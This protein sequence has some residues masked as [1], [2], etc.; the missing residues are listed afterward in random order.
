MV[1][2]GIRT[3]YRLLIC[4]AILAIIVILSITPGNGRPDDSVFSWLVINTATP[5]QKFMHITSYAVASALLVWSMKP[6][7][8][9]ASRMAVALVLAVMLGAGLEWAQTMV[10][11]RY[12]TLSDVILNSI[13]ATIGLIV[14]LAISY[15]RRSAEP[16]VDDEGAMRTSSES[17][18]C[19]AKRR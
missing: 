2:R 8:S 19:G 11:G 4:I 10:P 16:V 12:G 1:L 14:A 15:G 6:I 17:I 5:I 3:P 13:G 18:D 9:G 7:C